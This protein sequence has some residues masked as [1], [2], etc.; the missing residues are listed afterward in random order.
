MSG[1]PAYYKTVS[2][3]VA[4][5]KAA[6][7][8]DAHVEDFDATLSIPTAGEAR[9]LG[10]E[11]YGAGSKDVVL[12][13]TMVGGRGPVNGSVTAPMIYVGH[14]TAA[15]LI[16]RDMTGKIAVLHTT[17]NPGLYSADE[18]GRP[19][20]LIKAGAV[21]VIE[22]LE[23]PGNMQ[24]FDADRH[25][26]GTSLCVT[27]G[28]ED[29]YFLEGVLGKAA[30]AGKAVNARLSSTATLRTGQRSGNGVA[31]IPGKSKRTII[32]NAHADA[33]FVGANDNAGGLATLVALARYF[34]K[35]PQPEHTLV[36]VASAGHHTQGLGIPNFRLKH[37][38]DYVAPAD[39]IIN[40]EHLAASGMV[41]S[42]TTTWNNF[43]R[44]FVPTT[45]EWPMSVAVSNRAPFL[46]DLWRHGAR[47]FGL[48]T[49]RVVD[50]TPPGELGSYNHIS[51]MAGALNPE[52]KSAYSQL[53]D[54]NDVPLT[55]MIA[56]TVFY[57]TTGETVDSVPDEGLE[58]A[59]RFH[60]YLIA[61]ADKATTAQLRGAPSTPDVNC[62]P[63]P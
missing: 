18:N 60:A 26:C 50:T 27:V 39:L 1:T 38:A 12:H 31:T 10:D 49:Q 57:H 62:P 61:A 5:M 14:G 29:G 42:S 3:A 22:I 4:Q 37:E 41:R 9:I 40:L 30:A 11:G 23:Q 33:W 21:G 16:G 25:G 32:I 59:A 17:P 13:S 54:V 48:S 15:D 52:G 55:Q 24:S 7:L 19:A 6:G 35:Q 63:T 8:K 34:A 53:K 56:S 28:G 51:R 2:W 36:F 47:C 44:P 45:T 43:G 20:Q 46:I 58:R